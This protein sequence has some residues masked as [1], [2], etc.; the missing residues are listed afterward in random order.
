MAKVLVIDDEP[1]VRGVMCRV[2]EAVGHDVVDFGNGGGAIEH[3]RQQPADL[4]ITDLFM[5]DVEGIETIREIHRLRPDLPI[6]A[7]SGIDFEGGDYLN[8]ARKFG[9]VATLKKPFSPAD[10]L[11]LVSRVLSLA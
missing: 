4:L 7:V 2:L 5:P 9:A 10:L 8:V 1:G 3:V 6:I 11:D